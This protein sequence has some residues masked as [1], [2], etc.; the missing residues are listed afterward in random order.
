[1]R[2]FYFYW[3]VF[4]MGLL[5]GMIFTERKHALAR[6]DAEAASLNDPHFRKMQLDTQLKRALNPEFDQIMR[7]IEEKFGHDQ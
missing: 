4:A 2:R 1:L 3:V 6:R 5:I 7:D